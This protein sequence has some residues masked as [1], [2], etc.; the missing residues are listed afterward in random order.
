MKDLAE[1]NDIFAG[2]TDFQICDAVT[3]AI[4]SEY[5]F[6]DLLDRDPSIPVDRWAVHSVWGNTGFF[7]CNGYHQF[8]SADIDHQGFA[9]ALKEVGYPILASI[10]E[11]SIRLVPSEILR[12]HKAVEA[13][14]E[15]REAR[16][17]RAGLMDAKFITENPNFP[18]KIGA[19]IRA[20]KE[21]YLDLID[22]ISDAIQ[23]SRA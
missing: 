6:D 2:A 21:S 23:P 16:E 7:A 22:E 15:S 12:Y 14:T 1:L 4:E 10:L 13:H 20:R 17:K 18:D 19:Y 3:S 9:D 11:G 8:W 5:G